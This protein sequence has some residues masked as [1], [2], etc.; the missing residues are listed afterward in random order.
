MRETEKY[1]ESLHG[2]S[3]LEWTKVKMVIDEAFRCQKSEFEKGLKLADSEKV[4]K[5]TQSLFG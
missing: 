1:L 5:I 3:Y 4:K 2:I